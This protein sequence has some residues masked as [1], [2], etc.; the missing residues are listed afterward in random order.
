MHFQAD[1]RL[2]DQFTIDIVSSQFDEHESR[3]GMW[4]WL[5]IKIKKKILA[6]AKANIGQVMSH[7]REEYLFQ[8]A[9]RIEFDIRKKGPIINSR[10]Q[11]IDLCSGKQ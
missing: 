7:A 6:E 8:W 3:R 2:Y 5:K 4:L 9:F 10:D 11:I 1:F